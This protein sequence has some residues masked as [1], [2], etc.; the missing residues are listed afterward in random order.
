MAGM[1]N[2][3]TFKRIVS[4]A[5]LA[6]MLAGLLLTAVQQIQ[7]SQIILK[8]EVYE[9]AAAASQPAHV[10]ASVEQEHHEHEHEHEVWQPANGAERTLFTALANISLAVG[11]G[12]L[13]GAAICLRGEVSGW[14]AGLLWGVAG[15]TVF[16]VAPSL[17]LPPE[18]PGT[19][20]APLADRQLWWLITVGMTASGLSLLI[21][22]RTWQV[23]ILGAILLGVPHLIGAPQ[24]QVHASAAPAELAHAFIYATAI[25]NAVFWLALGSL[26]GFFYKKFA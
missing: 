17:G 21:F 24:P 9:D 1:F 7:V 19:E 26:M 10:H 15:Y 25:A 12:L 4:A 2:L 13:L 8:A 16:F 20:A 23:K 18:V 11:F 22:A 14:R 5:A 3:R 6:G